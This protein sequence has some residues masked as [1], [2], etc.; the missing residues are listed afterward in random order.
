MRSGIAGVY[1]LAYIGSRSRAQAWLAAN[2][3]PLSPTSCHPSS[4]PDSPDWGPQRLHVMMRYGEGPH[5]SALSILGFALAASYLALRN[6]RPA[7]LVVSEYCAPQWLRT[8]F[9]ARRGWPC[10]FRS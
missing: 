9:M 7:V 4:G 10:F 6:W 3:T 2:S 1:W 5:I 8:T